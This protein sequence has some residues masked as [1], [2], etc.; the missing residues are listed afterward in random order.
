MQDNGKNLGFWVSGHVA[1]GVCIIVAN[2]VIFFRFNNYTG[3]GEW[4]CTGM[5]LAFFTILYIESLLPMFPQT[6]YI[7]DTMMEQPLIWFQIISCTMLA[8]IVEMYVLPYVVPR[9][10]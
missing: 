1:Y 6:Y 2:I 3:W 5:C 4:T 8:S 10:R 9:I 7:F